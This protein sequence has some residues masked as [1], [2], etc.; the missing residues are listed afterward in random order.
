MYL[1]FDCET[2]GVHPKS[3]V[4]Q[5]AWQL[6][7]RYGKLKNTAT[8]IVYPEGFE[9]PSAAAQ[10]HGITT[11]Q[12]TAEGIDLA[13][14]L[15]RFDAALQQAHWLVAHNVAF[16]IRILSGEYERLGKLCA[17]GSKPTR[18]T[19]SETR[20]YVAIRRENAHK[21]P[22]L[23]ELYEHVF[24]QPFLGAHNAAYDVAA[25]AACF[26]ALLRRGI[27]PPSDDTK[28]EDIAYKAPGRSDG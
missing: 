3:R 20:D 2:T 24:Q 9:I 13:I 15:N 1:I 4:V 17:L 6:H 23:T 21:A 28:A 18:D 5:L 22:K 19:M 10:I 12:A 14:V 26:F 7:D 8:D 11:E 16:D 25:T 27:L